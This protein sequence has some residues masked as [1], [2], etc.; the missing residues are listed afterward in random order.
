MGCFASKPDDNVIGIT[1]S[2]PTANGG[3]TG[4]VEVL[5]AG[6]G[7]GGADGFTTRY[8]GGDGGGADGG[9]DGGGAG[10]CGGC[11]GCGG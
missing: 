5:F 11:G 7:G 4:G 10:G 6:D 3:G 8:F 1:G 9:G 2:N